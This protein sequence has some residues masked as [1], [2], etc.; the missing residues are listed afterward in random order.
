[1]TDYVTRE[2]DPETDREY[3]AEEIREIRRLNAESSMTQRDIADRFGMS[4]PMIS[5]IVRR[6]QYAWVE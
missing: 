5:E 2:M 4:Q 3:R 6:V 1:M